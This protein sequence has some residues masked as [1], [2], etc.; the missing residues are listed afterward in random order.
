MSYLI[1]KAFAASFLSLTF[2]FG[3][4]AG[5]DVPPGNEGPYP[6][7]DIRIAYE[8]ANIVLESLVLT[9]VP[10]SGVYEMHISQ[11]GYASQSDIRQSGDFSI[12][13]S[14]DGLLGIFSLSRRSGGYVATLTVHWDDG[15]PDCTRQ[16]GT[17]HQL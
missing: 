11:G 6:S 14:A 9:P 15:T 5:G 10:V 1:P 8:G 12:A 7:C 2:A 17:S 4:A 3:A 13:P 16:I